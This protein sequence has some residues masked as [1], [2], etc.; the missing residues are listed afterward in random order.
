MKMFRTLL[1]PLLLGSFAW[2]QKIDPDQVGVKLKPVSLVSGPVTGSLCV[3][4]NG[5]VSWFNLIPCGPLD[6]TFPV[7]GQV[8]VYT[9]ANRKYKPGT[10][11]GRGNIDLGLQGQQPI[12]DAGSAKYKPQ[13]QPFNDGRDLFDCSYATDAAG[14]LN[15]YTAAG[16]GKNPTAFDGSEFNGSE[17]VFPQGCHLKLGSTWTIQNHMGFS[18]R[19]NSS[20]GAGGTFSYNVPTISYCGPS[21]GTTVYMGRVHSFTVENLTINGQGP[22]CAEGAANG[23]VVDKAGA[24]DLNTTFGLFRNVKISGGLQ[25]AHNPNFVGLNFSPTQ[26]SNVEDMIIER[27]SVSCSEVG[28]GIGAHTYGIRFNSSFNT[29]AENLNHVNI[30]GCGVGV[31]TG[32]GGVAI[33]DGDYASNG[34]DISWGGNADPTIIDNI[35]TEHSGRFFDGHG[36]G[37]GSF[38]VWIGN[39]HIAPG[40]DATPN[41]AQIDLGTA[42]TIGINALLINNGF[43]SPP[44]VSGYFPLAAN[45]YAHVT[46]INNTLSAPGN[47]ISLSGPSGFILPNGHSFG[48]DYSWL[49][50]GYMRMGAHPNGGANDIGYGFFDSVGYERNGIAYN[51]TTL[52]CLS[53]WLCIPRDGVY[54]SEGNIIMTGVR[55]VPPDSISCTPVGPAGAGTNWTIRVFPF[56]RAGKRAGLM[57]AA[58]NQGRCFAAAA[59]LDNTNYLHVTWTGT[60]GAVTYD[61]IVLNPINPNGQAW[62]AGNTASTTFDIKSTPG[63]YNYLYPNYYDAARTTI[64]GELLAINAHTKFAPS[65]D[66]PTCD[67]NHRF[68]LNFIAG[69]IGIKDIVQVCAKDAADTYAWRTVY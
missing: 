29:K 47:G 46:M 40:T 58:G 7:D 18:L 36:G 55:P 8:L 62:L 12:W 48:N 65:T 24:G 44:A 67:A 52:P 31:D 66:T 14:A 64:N 10:F 17:T 59:T 4:I 30:G 38:P 61:V 63:A 49:R 6:D 37:G 41:K 69:A 23:I 54:L 22:G 53:G 1:F 20:P 3:V 50:G 28:S 51:N 33:R 9:Q 34:V 16:G 15:T 60:P 43:D 35:T 27:S 45:Q 19:G 5:D 32:V 57:Q 56:D 11:L 42:S 39:N 13:N 26:L 2:A 21:N 25:G 68:Q